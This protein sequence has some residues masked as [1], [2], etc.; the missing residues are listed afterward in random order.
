MIESAG[1]CEIT[2]SF[3]LVI[4]CTVCSTWIVS[5]VLRTVIGVI[6]GEW[7]AFYVVTFQVVDALFQFGAQDL[8]DGRL[9]V[10]VG[11]YYWSRLLLV[12]LVVDLDWFGALDFE[13]VTE[14]FEL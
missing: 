11:L 1:S 4:I 7:A 9:L 13:F 3:V 5:T 10:V 14:T 12:G 2:F 6:V 8:F